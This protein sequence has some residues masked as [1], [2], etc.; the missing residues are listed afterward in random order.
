MIFKY[1]RIV[2]KEVQKHKLEYS[3]LFLVFLT[4]LFVRVYRLGDLLGFYYDQGR[5]ALVIWRLWHEGKPFLIGPVTGLAGLFLGPLFYYLISPF[6]LIG[7]GNPVY[8]AVFLAFLSTTAISLLYF[9]GKRMHSR[10]SGFLAVIIASFSYYIVLA[11]R[12]LSNPTPVMLTSVLLL[13][14]MW[15]I[16]NQKSKVRNQKSN[17]FWVAS[18][19][20]IGISMHFES[21]SAIFYLPLFAVFSVWVY[22]SDRKKFPSVKT[23]IIA[24]A[25]F[26]FTLLPQLLFNFRHD[27]ILFNNFKRVFSEERSIG[28]PF[29]SYN[30][31]RKQKYFIGVFESKIFPGTVKSKGLFVLAAVLGLLIASTKSKKLITLFIIFLGVPVIGYIFYQ[32][33]HG[34]IFDYYMTGYYLPMIL[35]FSLGLATLWKNFIGKIIVVGFLIAFLN[36]NLEPLKNYL[37]AGVDGPTHI[38]LGNQLQVVDWVYEDSTGRGEF[39]V[40]VYVPPVIPYAYDYLFLWQGNRLCGVELCG[41]VEDRRGLIYILYEVDPPHPERLENWLAKYE[42]NTIIEAEERY[43][44]IFVQRRQRI[45][46]D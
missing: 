15:E 27:N 36:V 38:T 29:T 39:N 19:F 34:N 41:M 35:L 43:G 17:F 20:L 3:L 25:L 12:W 32:G 16:V 23:F 8:P 24:G 6:Y 37:S 1:L 45:I 21:A 46:N 11:G 42:D 28:T 30:L 5:D 13:W 2:R 44:G 4:A 10:T 9:L 33:N 18:F 14:S 40:D 31:N 26:F 22:L 7:G